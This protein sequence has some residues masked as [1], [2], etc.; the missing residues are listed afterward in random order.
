MMVHNRTNDY[1]PHAIFGASFSYARVEA[2]VS[3]VL[4]SPPQLAAQIAAQFCSASPDTLPVV[5]AAVFSQRDVETPHAILVQTRVPWTGALQAAVR[6]L[7]VGDLENPGVLPCA[8]QRTVS[9][10]AVELFDRY[11][12]SGGSMLSRE[13]VLLPI[14]DVQKFMLLEINGEL[15]FRAGGRFHRDIVSSTIREF[16]D[17]GLAKSASRVAPRGGGFVGLYR[18]GVCLFGESTDFGK[19]NFPRVRELIAS[20]VPNLPVAIK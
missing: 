8:E 7:L 6:D 9:E 15:F 10:K 19:A 3:A 12:L 5:L 13:P 14:Q 16:L 11:V 17:G 1:D 2:V 4:E 20:Q 18:D